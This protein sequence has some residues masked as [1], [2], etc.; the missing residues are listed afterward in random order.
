MKWVKRLWR[1]VV[2][3]LALC[4]VYSLGAGVVNK[5]TFLPEP[6][7]CPGEIY[8]LE[9]NKV[10]GICALGRLSTF[11]YGGT[12]V[13]R[14]RLDVWVKDEHDPVLYV[15][16]EENRVP[17]C[18]FRIKDLEVR[19]VR[20]KAPDSCKSVPFNRLTYRQ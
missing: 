9:L 7:S 5:G 6:T 8:E 12:H 20:G 17:D 11:V 14:M 18:G 19:R 13:D 1:G 10:P 4:G 16:T 15:W 2:Y 3:S